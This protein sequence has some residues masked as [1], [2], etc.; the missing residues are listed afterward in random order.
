MFKAYFLITTKSGFSTEALVKIRAL[1]GIIL[2]NFDLAGNI[3]AEVQGTNQYIFQMNKRI[4]Q[5][6][7]VQ[8]TVTYIVD[9]SS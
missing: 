8:A 9:L 1:P 4:M 7:Q 5:V 6:D 2:A 3:I